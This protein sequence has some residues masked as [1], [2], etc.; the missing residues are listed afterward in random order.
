MVRRVKIRLIDGQLMY[1]VKI[2]KK[3]RIII[4][5]EIREY[6]SAETFG[7]KV[8]EGGKIVLIPLQGEG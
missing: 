3:G 8:V 7:V 6:V 5:K 4:P 1:V 2:D